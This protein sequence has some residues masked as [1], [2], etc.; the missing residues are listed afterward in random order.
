[1]NE[2]KAKTNK[3]N[4]G[5]PKPYELYTSHQWVKESQLHFDL[6]LQLLWVFA[7]TELC[8]TKKINPHSICMKYESSL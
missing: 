2:I 5:N 4:K 8:L 3:L 7:I 1:M 6:K